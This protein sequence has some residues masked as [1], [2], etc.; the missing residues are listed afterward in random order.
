MVIPPT[1]VSRRVEQVYEKTNLTKIEKITMKNSLKVVFLIHNKKR[2]Q[3]CPFNQKPTVIRCGFSSL[4][5]PIAS[6]NP[7]RFFD[8]FVDKPDLS[9]LD[10]SS[11]IIKTEGHT[12]FEQ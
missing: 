1:S 6:E 11:K 8:A 7:I 4:E 10:F 5:E 12:T 2:F 9:N 3:P